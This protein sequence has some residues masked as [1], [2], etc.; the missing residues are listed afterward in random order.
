M[1]GMATAI[2]SSL[3]I[4]FVIILVTEYLRGTP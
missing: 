4:L 1:I 3:L 2:G